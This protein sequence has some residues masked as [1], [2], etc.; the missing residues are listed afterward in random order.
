M[1]IWQRYRENGYE[2][3]RGLFLGEPLYHMS[4]CDDGRWQR[5]PSPYTPA[6]RMTRMGSGG[7]TGS[8][9]TAGSGST[10]RRCGSG[11]TAWRG[12]AWPEARSRSSSSAAP[13]T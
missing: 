11:R 12:Q 8:G 5:P 7:A 9:R 1:L 3:R 6:P 10:R 4:R 2:A 13:T